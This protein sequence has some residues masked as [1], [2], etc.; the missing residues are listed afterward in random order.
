[1]IPAAG[2]AASSASESASSDPSPDQVDGNAHFSAGRF[3]AA[4]DAYTRAIGCAPS[5][6]LFSNRAA[7]HLKL[8]SYGSA[9]ADAEA[10]LRLDASFVKA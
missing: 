1:M 7:T 5:A 3:T 10:A 6:A 2:A 9:I 4:L 8:E